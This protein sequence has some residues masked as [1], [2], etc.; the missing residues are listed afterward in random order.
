M[1]VATARGAR[2]FRQVLPCGLRVRRVL[3]W[4]AVHY[5][6]GESWLAVHYTGEK[7]PAGVIL[8]GEKSIFFAA[9]PGGEKEASCARSTM[10]QV[11]SPEVVNVSL[12]LT[13]ELRDAAYA[14]ARLRGTNFSSLA[15]YAIARE[16]GLPEAEAQAHAIDAAA[17]KGFR[18]ATGE[19]LPSPQLAGCKKVLTQASG[20]VTNSAMQ[21]IMGKLIKRLRRLT[22]ER[23]RKTELASW[24]GVPRQ[25]VHDWL[26]ERVSPSGETTL[27]LLEWVA[28]E[29]AKFQTEAP[30]SAA[31]P[32]GAKAQVRKSN[33]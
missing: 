27:R 17:V 29:E 33:T 4:L 28:A 7:Y 16:I 14:T 5:T 2:G 13:R 25:S 21:P 11:H 31:A 23:G 18:L 9:R 20:S 24:L 19:L 10:P 1:P 32:A 6:T 3:R 30:A 8:Q 15:R 22:D 12:W 26:S